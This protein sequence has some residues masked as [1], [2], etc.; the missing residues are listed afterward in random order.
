MEIR[1]RSSNNNSSSY[2]LNNFEGMQPRSNES[3]YSRKNG[4]GERREL[5]GKGTGV[6]KDQGKRHTSIASNR[7]P[8][9]RPPPGSGSEPNRKVKKCR[10]ETLAYKRSFMSRSGG[11][12][13]KNRKGTG[14]KVCY[15]YCQMNS[16][17][18]SVKLIY[19]ASMVDRLT[20]FCL[21]VRDEIGV[22]SIKVIN[23]PID[24]RSSL[25]VAKSESE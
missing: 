1:S 8:L 18:A 7:R 11:P 24:T 6:K 22:S 12:E 9:V 15:T 25:F 3:Q 2:L 13:K 16:L 19:S 20:D 14:H 23:P 10:K 4:S 21:K 17:A 5:E